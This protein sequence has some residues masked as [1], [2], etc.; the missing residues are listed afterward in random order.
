[1]EQEN[2]PANILV[3][4]AKQVSFPNWNAMVGE[5]GQKFARRSSF[6]KEIPSNA[7]NTDITSLIDVKDVTDFLPKRGQSS[8]HGD[9]RDAISQLGEITRNTESFPRQ[10]L[11]YVDQLNTNSGS[12]STESI[13]TR[14]NSSSSR[15]PIV[16]YC[17]IIKEDSQELDE[18][19]D[20]RE[21]E[22]TSSKIH[23]SSVSIVLKSSKGRKRQEQEADMREEK[24]ETE[25][26]KKEGEDRRE[27]IINEMK[28]KHGEKEIKN[29]YKEI[30]NDKV[31]DELLKEGETD[32]KSELKAM[33]DIQ[34]E[35]P[36]EI[37][38]FEGS[39][40]TP[41]VAKGD[42]APGPFQKQRRWRTRRTGAIDEGLLTADYDG[43]EN[44]TAKLKH[45]NRFR[46]K[47]SS[48][49]GM[50]PL[51]KETEKEVTTISTTNDSR[52]RKMLQRRRGT[53]DMGRVDA[54]R[55]PMLGSKEQRHHHHHHHDRKVDPSH[56]LMHLGKRRGSFNPTYN[57][58]NTT[59]QKNRRNNATR[60]KSLFICQTEERTALRERLMKHACPELRESLEK[61]DEEQEKQNRT[62]GVEEC[63]KNS[64]TTYRRPLRKSISFD[65]KPEILENAREMAEFYERLKK[66]G[67]VTNRKAP[68]VLSRTVKSKEP[69]ATILTS[70][71]TETKV[72][73]NNVGLF[74]DSRFSKGRG[75]QTRAQSNFAG[76]PS[77]YLGQLREKSIQH[78]QIFRSQSDSISSASS[79][80]GGEVADPFPMHSAAKNGGQRKLKKLV[81]KGMDVNARDAEGW[82][83]IHYALSSGNF[84]TVA[85]LL[86]VGADINDYTK[87]RTSKYFQ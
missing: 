57:Q 8:G 45:Q 56:Y 12:L 19:P 74:G 24:N 13:K 29:M 71:E 52:N 50:L 14:D 1:M 53:V 9:D 23:I 80:D 39:E 59:T 46:K 77:M 22:S 72:F 28:E 26:G 81:S 67:Q 17:E 51:S 79:S 25:T 84:E 7:R 47:S 78:E 31:N 85:F 6:E 4:F 10:S 64:K 65:S 66:C 3:S 75:R 58:F 16:R 60:A 69:K 41:Y 33:D 43:T 34:E 86:K 54:N 61:D 70:S 87:G 48:F 55:S 40:K 18:A 37:R 73:T 27:G 63:E 62:V 38:S 49:S 35:G 76:V 68:V 21:T 5:L 11:N 82:P 30:E 44:E 36:V 20:L 83:P 15:K 42:A 32:E 2:F